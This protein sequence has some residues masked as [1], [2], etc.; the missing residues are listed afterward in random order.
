LSNQKKK[1]EERVGADQSSSPN[2]HSADTGKGGGGKREGEKKRRQRVTHLA[3]NLQKRGGKGGK[4]K[5]GRE[6]KCVS[7]RIALGGKAYA[8]RKKIEKGRRKGGRGPALSNVRWRGE[9]RGG[10][11]WVTEERIFPPSSPFGCR[12]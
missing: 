11:E 6:G 7:H 10:G 12:R 3:S 5:S 4:E 2:F 1:K 8:K 9:K